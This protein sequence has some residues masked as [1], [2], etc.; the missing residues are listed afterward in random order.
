MLDSSVKHHEFSSIRSFMEPRISSLLDDSLLSQNSYTL[1]NHSSQVSG[2]DS[3]FSSLQPLSTPSEP[4]INDNTLPVPKLSSH[5]AIND[6]ATRHTRTV[7]DFVNASS[8]TNGLPPG[9]QHK[10]RQ[11]GAT[12]SLAKVLNHG[13]TPKFSEALIQYSSKD[14]TCVDGVVVTEGTAAKDLLTLPEPKPA[15]KGARKPRIPPLLQGLHHPPPDAGLFPPITADSIV[16]VLSGIP[17]NAHATSSPRRSHSAQNAAEGHQRD[18]IIS[19][20]EKTKVARQRRK[21]SNEE[22][23]DLLR[24]V[25]KHG[26]GRWKEILQDPEL[27][28]NDRRT[29]DLKDR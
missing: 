14:T 13:G 12:V 5:V 2:L 10:L 28:F 15:R 11:T 9:P 1:Q 6:Q 22:T 25:K 7:N 27:V 19:A 8:N 3:N 26:I 18:A 29:V 17:A 20:P 4:T 23:K 24:G 21:W 16:P